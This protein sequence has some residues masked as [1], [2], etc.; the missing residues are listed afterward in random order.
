MVS[1]SN[2]MT[3]LIGC[4]FSFLGFPFGVSIWNHSAK[5][6][7]SLQNKPWL[8]GRLLMLCLSIYLYILFFSC[9][10]SSI[11]F[12]GETKDTRPFAI[13]GLIGLVFFALT[14]RKGQTEQRKKTT[15]NWVEQELSEIAGQSRDVVVHCRPFPFKQK[16]DGV[17]RKYVYPD[18][19]SDFRYELMDVQLADWNS[20]ETELEQRKKKTV[21]VK[22]AKCKEITIDIECGRLPPKQQFFSDLADAIIDALSKNGIQPK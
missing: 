7:M 12:S 19:G 1:A 10:L 22:L 13:G 5:C 9:I 11:P 16:K 21:N 17:R 18:F 20:L 14:V 2:I 8:V 15:D 4:A 6:F 3:A